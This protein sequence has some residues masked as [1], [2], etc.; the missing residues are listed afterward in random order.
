MKTNFEIQIN[1]STVKIIVRGKTL[2]DIFS[3]SLKGIASYLKPQILCFKKP[4]LKEWKKIRVEAVDVVSLLIEFISSIIVYID[5]HSAVYSEIV[6]EKFEEN[7]LEGKIF[8]IKEKNSDKEIGDVSY[9]GVDISK[10]EKTGF[11]EATLV[12]AI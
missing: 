3:N 5:E 12:F 11:F 10:N 8:G 2:E 4:Q 7:F 6:F 1:D 9:D